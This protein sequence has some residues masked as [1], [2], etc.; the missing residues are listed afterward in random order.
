VLA[1]A[2]GPVRAVFPASEVANRT[3]STDP[4][5]VP[6]YATA[7]GG[8]SLWQFATVAGVSEALAPL[9][10]RRRALA[11]YPLSQLKHSL[12]RR[13]LDRKRVHAM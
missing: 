1:L 9:R 4:D 13:F 11:A 12:G 5:D 2:L 8:R 7:P 10:R 6:D 3:Q